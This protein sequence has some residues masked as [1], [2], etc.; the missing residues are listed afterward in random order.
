MK[1][2]YSEKSPDTHKV[3]IASEKYSIL[4][5]IEQSINNIVDIEFDWEGKRF[6]KPSSETLSDAIDLMK[7]LLLQIY[8]NNDLWSKWFD[9]FIYSNEVGYIC[10]GWHYED[11]ALHFRIK[12]NDMNYRK[13]WSSS[14]KT[15]SEKKQL[16]LQNCISLWKWLIE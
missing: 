12:N 5:E 14:G 13:I 15:K 11:K 3:T 16:N 7:S 2:D 8:L 1:L 10:I 9:P 4:Q 6:E